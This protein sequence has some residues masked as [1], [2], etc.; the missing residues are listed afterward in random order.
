MMFEDKII[1]GVLKHFASYSRSDMNNEKST[2][3]E[4]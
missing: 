4:C 1:I 2:V 3:A